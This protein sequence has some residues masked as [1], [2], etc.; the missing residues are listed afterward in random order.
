MN[1][2]EVLYRGLKMTP[3][4]VECYIPGNKINLIGYTSTSTS[5]GIA[6]SFAFIDL[7]DKMLPVVF[8]IHFKSKT[9]L[10]RMTKEY[11]AFADEDEILVQDGLQYIIL[12]NT[13]Q[14]DEGTKI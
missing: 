9:G 4:K 13:E 7:P 10:F 2:Q 1:G 12:N 3:K 5:M 8:K 6:L 14:I 11:S